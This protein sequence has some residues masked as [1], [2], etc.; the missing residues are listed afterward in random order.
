[1]RTKTLC[2]YGLGFWI[3]WLLVT[4][5]ASHAQPTAY[6][7]KLNRIAWSYSRSGPGW[8]ESDIV[9]YGKV[10]TLPNPSGEGNM[11]VTLNL[12]D[13]IQTDRG[14]TNT[15]SLVAP[16]CSWPWYIGILGWGSDTNYLDTCVYGE[17]NPVVISL[18]YDW[19][20]LI[21][22]TNNSYYY[23]VTQTASPHFRDGTTTKVFRQGRPMYPLFRLYLAPNGTRVLSASPEYRYSETPPEP[24]LDLISL[25]QKVRLPGTFNPVFTN[26]VK[27]QFLRKD[28]GV[29]VTAES[30]IE[31]ISA[32]N[33]TVR[34]P[35]DLLGRNDRIPPAETFNSDVTIRIITG[36]P[37]TPRTNDL[38][39]RLVRPRL[40]VHDEVFMPPALPAG[41]APAVPTTPRTLLQ[42]LLNNPTN[43]NDPAT[44]ATFMFLGQSA[45]GRTGLRTLNTA[46]GSVAAGPLRLADGVRVFQPGPAG[47]NF[48][49]VLPFHLP[50]QGAGDEALQFDV[51]RNGVHVIVVGAD[52]S[53]YG[54]F[55]APF[56]VHLSGNV[57]LPRK[58]VNGTL[59]SPRGTRLDTLFNH[60]APRPQTLNAT[61]S[62]SAETALFKFANPVSVSSYAVAVL[63]PP[64][65]AGFPLGTPIVRAADPPAPL[66]VTTP[67]ARTL[68]AI[69]PAA[70]TVVD[71]TQVPDPASVVV[72]PPLAGSVCA[73]IGEA[74][75]QG[76][77]LP[78]AAGGVT[79]SSLIFDL[80]S[81]QEAVDGPGAD[82]SV[83]ALAGT[84]TVAVANTP[85]AG[86]DFDPFV[87]LPGTFSG[88]TNF[89]LAGTG[90]SL[91]RYVRV[92]AAPA[93][94]LDAVRK[95]NVLCDRLEPSVGAV[96]RVPTATI[97]ARRA[98]A[99]MTALDPFVWLI[100]PDG[101]WYA[102]NE[103]GF[104]DD[105]SVDRSDAAII[106]ATLGASSFYRFLVKGYDKQPD[107]QAL[108]SF[109]TRLETPG[110]YDPVELQISARDEAATAAQKQ[111]RISDTRQRDSYLFQAAPGLPIN[112]VVSGKGAALD[113]VVELY[114]P[115]DFLIGANDNYPGRDKN[116]ALTITLP[117]VSVAGAALPNPSTYR[118]VVSAVDRKGDPAGATGVNAFLRLPATGDYELKGFTGQMTNQSPVVAAPRIDS[119]TPATAAVG[120]T[121]TLAGANFSPVPAN[122]EV[123]IGGALASVI[124]ASATQLRVVV[125]S[126]VAV[127][128]APLTV[129]VGGLTSPAAS[130]VV[131]ESG[132]VAPPLGLVGWWPGE[133]TANDLAGTNHGTLQGGVT[134][135]SGKVGQA[136]SFNGTDGT[137]AVGAW[138]PG[139]AW[140]I[141]AWVNPG[142]IGGGRK[143]IAGGFSDCRDW[144]L[145]LQDG[146][147]AVGIRPLGSCSQSLSSGVTANTNTWYYV[148]GTCDGATARIYVDGQLR[149]SGPVDNGYIGTPAGVRIGGEVWTGGNNFS[150][151]ID[152][153]T[154]YNRAL[155]PD[156]IVAIFA[157]GGQG[158][159]KEALAGPW[160]EISPD[161]L[162]F[163]SPLLGQSKELTL[164]VRNLGGMALTIK[165]LNLDNGRFAIVSTAVPF[166]LDPKGTAPVLLR[167]TPGTAGQETG[168]LTLDSND[169][170]RPAAGVSLAGQGAL[171]DLGGTLAGALSRSNS[172]YR[173]TS[174]LYVPS[175]QTLI[176]EPGV[177]LQF[178]NPGVGLTVDGTLIAR[179]T[180]D[181]PILFTSDKAVKQPGQWRS[182]V[183]RDSSVDTNTVMEYC[184][185]EYG[186]ASGA[187]DEIIRLDYASPTISHCT[188]RGS[189]ANGVAFLHSE[190][191]VANCQFAGNAG[192]AMA[193]R[194]DSFARL[195]NNTA[196]GN[197]QNA[198]A[199]YD[200][201]P[202]RSGTWVKDNLPYTLVNYVGINAG[203]TLTVEPGV[204]VQFQNADTHLIV[205]GSLRAVGT[206]DQPIVFTSDEVT[207][208][209]GQWGA[210]IFRASS[211]ETNTL[212]ENCVVEYGGNAAV[213]NE[214]VRFENSSPTLR[215]CL[216]RG[217]RAN[218]VNF[219]NSEARVENC[220]L[221][222]NAGF[223]MAMRIDS[224]VRLK[225]NTA[226]GNG[227]NVIAIYDSWP[228][229]RAPGSKTTCPTP[230]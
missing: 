194:I 22:T 131:T 215:S 204:I 6:Y 199:I 14:F 1:M 197:G 181:R 128:A 67:T 20:A 41:A 193:M 202:G 13:F 195:K 81:G 87:S 37:G 166:T 63:L 168:S 165:T 123:R 30:P 171:A 113:P 34:V 175:D 185:V 42:F 211:L 103:S 198:I 220:Q 49:V 99:P 95:L 21:D 28:E 74:D 189:R 66:E 110:K 78:L 11:T 98:K 89:D 130:F 112:I 226:V 92:T 138:S 118:I 7:Y 65:S 71:F 40:L 180:V 155:S 32:T 76:V 214:N 52:P 108:G 116:A 5:C 91:A 177:T 191:R 82:F 73:A 229:V 213:G 145:V 70:A 159:N 144:G 79:V 219:L 80:G 46:M 12:P 3:V 187:A 152:E 4:P 135:A 72:A 2:R 169:P 228:G 140:T 223:A 136:L 83:V 133:G 15:F 94:T 114:D 16:Q 84:Y 26:H 58:L 9:G 124:S 86:P 23:E 43:E 105:L 203:Q 224:F 29:A 132:R 60:P 141:E 97:L 62:G 217:S 207:K 192:F 111:G 216:L 51:L 54:P 45:D 127:G 39:V 206:V 69:A 143:G 139:S 68:A 201:W 38:A 173:V 225:N 186:A 184:Q 35:V 24:T 230:W 36:L 162:D 96:T 27:V 176:I 104:G 107:N 190:A 48:E 59:E 129:S 57:G 148:V 8:P 125:P 212:M 121:L 17:T 158:K 150:G 90:L 146:I 196:I 164:T 210:I 88:A 93:V 163:G 109:F 53:S 161:T 156:E 120:A 101:Q 55:P 115:E 170:N 147:F 188:I 174:E 119:V 179:G 157:A 218:G 160:I 208:G 102:E 167:F 183:F 221:V 134:Y 31:A 149:N 61:S 56:Q 77:A 182:I 205:E 117:A 122:D 10:V 126:G 178:Q 50:N 172:P 44:V 137:V 47:G 200:S 19:K 209:P 64:T 227:Q 18:S 153:L 151:L 142:A 106:Q 100:A 222:G 33:V 154:I 85:Y 75:G 25:G